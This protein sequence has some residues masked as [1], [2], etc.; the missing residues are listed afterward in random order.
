[1][2]IVKFYEKGFDPGQLIVQWNLGNTCNYSCEYCP[3]ILH[4]G[5]RLWVDL[6]LIENTLLKIKDYFPQKTLRVEFLGGEITLYRDFINLM[7][8]CKDQNI[9]NMIF[10]NASRT[11]RHWE[12]VADY[13]DEV[14]LTFHPATTSK[15]HFEKIVKFFIEK[16]IKLYVHIAMQK[17][18]F[19]SSAKYAEYLHVTYPNLKINM[20]LMM[21]KEHK[22][23]FD[24]YFYD[25]SQEE[26]DLIKLYDNSEERYIAEYEDGS[27]TQYNISEI[28]DLKLN[29]FKGFNCGTTNSIINIDA[30]GV[31]STSLC[32]QKSKINIYI[33][34]LDQ[35]FYD[36]ICQKDLCENPSDIRIYKIYKE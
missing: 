17:S 35:L 5:T 32:R 4:N 23:S 19:A 31:A 24:G 21:D 25:Y 18:L 34:D 9:N 6:P 22:K 36:H 2:N 28:K 3:S 30:N 13:L 12:E 27:T 10:T 33:D 11:F 26:I 29:N 7:K 20:V 15:I 16:N 1:M 14:M 8:F